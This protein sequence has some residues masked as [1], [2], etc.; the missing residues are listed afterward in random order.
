MTSI[1]SICNLA[2]TN[3]GK[4]TISSLTETGAEARAC[5]QL[6]GITRDML[7]QS[8]PWRFALKTASLAEITNIH[9]KTWG[10][11]FIRPS[12]CLK[13]LYVKTEACPFDAVS[14][15]GTPYMIEGDRV[16]TNINPCFLH[17]VAKL[18][19]P[20]RFPPMFV[21]TLSWHLAA[22]LAMPL[23]RDPKVR[24]DAYQLARAMQAQ[25]EVSDANEVRE[26]SDHTSE[27]VMS[28]DGPV[29]AV[30]ISENNSDLA[31]VW[32]DNGTWED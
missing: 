31:S 3:I 28:R 24:A 26:N 32:D 9:N 11:S 14:A 30:A 6:Y 10:Y 16:F 19:D 5:N 21:D 25:A 27:L 7:L 13:V 22:R 2:L 1:V 23:T 17:Y 4:Q 18:E 8:Y 20:T 12:D 29:A 15:A